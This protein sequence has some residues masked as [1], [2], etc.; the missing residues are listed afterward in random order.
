MLRGNDARDRLND[1]ERNV[2]R[3]DRRGRM[4]LEIRRNSYVLHSGYIIQQQSDKDCNNNMAS[5]DEPHLEE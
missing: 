5:G 2:W 1:F 3:T 4:V